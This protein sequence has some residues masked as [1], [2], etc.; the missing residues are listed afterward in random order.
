VGGQDDEVAL[1]LQGDPVATDAIPDP[2]PQDLRLLLG[3]GRIAGELVFPYPGGDL[4][5]GVDQDGP[6]A[7]AGFFLLAVDPAANIDLGCR[8]APNSGENLKISG[9]RFRTAGWARRF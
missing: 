2:V 3:L 6:E 9:S 1:A 5:K 4:A 8:T 7:H